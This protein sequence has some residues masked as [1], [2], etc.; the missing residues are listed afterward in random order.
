MPLGVA[1]LHAWPV[2]SSV[3]WNKWLSKWESV[4]IYRQVIITLM[5]TC[6]W[7]EIKKWLLRLKLRHSFLTKEGRHYNI[8]KVPPK[9]IQKEYVP[10]QEW[11]N[12]YPCLGWLDQ[13]WDIPSRF[14]VAYPDLGYSNVEVGFLLMLF[15][16]A[17]QS[18]AFP[19]TKGYPFK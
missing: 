15:I 17:L 8:S 9:G 11:L 10:T 16:T 12:F 2:F 5:I 3:A 18:F 7:Q 14:G 4:S 6:S 1:G 13:V 19:N